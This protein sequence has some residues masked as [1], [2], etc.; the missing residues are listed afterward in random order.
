MDIIF[1]DS[2]VDATLCVL[3][4]HLGLS[5][6]QKNTRTQS[7]ADTLDDLN[8]MLFCSGDQL[9]GTVLYAM[10]QETATAILSHILERPVEEMDAL[11]YLSIAEFGKLIRSQVHQRLVKAGLALRISPPALVFGSDS[12][13]PQLEM[14]GVLVPLHTDWGPVQ[15]HFTLV[16]MGNQG[17]DRWNGSR[18]ARYSLN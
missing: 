1:F 4:G 3:S 14:P 8:I 15:V 2:F 9:R 17:Q 18:V 7:L 10:G 6:R 13:A 5:V 16:E 11:A 12:S